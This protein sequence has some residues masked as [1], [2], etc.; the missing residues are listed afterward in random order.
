MSKNK[1]YM[2]LGILI[3]GAILLIINGFT[4]ARY[5]ANSIWN[6]YLKSKGFYFGSDDLSMNGTT[7]INNMWD[8]GNVYFNLTNSLND[9]VATDNDITY[10]VT[11]EVEGTD[12]EENECSVYGST[13]VSGVPT[14]QKIYGCK[15]YKDDGVDTSSL[16]QS[17]CESGG[18]NWKNL[19]VYKELYFNVVN[20]VGG[21]TNDVA[22]NIIATSLTP[23]RKTITGRFV[24]HRASSNMGTVSL[25]Y[26]NY[27]DNDRLVVTNSYNETRCV[28][29]TWNASQLLIDVD[30]TNLISHSTDENGYIND[31]RFNLIGKDS[32]SYI[33]YK[34][35]IQNVYDSSAF[36]IED[37]DEC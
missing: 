31:I 34:R 24:L 1:K 28:H 13:L 21:Q 11:C 2:F 6:Y 8:G 26:H 36:T 33:F 35:N 3:L 14:I 37:D 15:N 20:T 27:T 19:S 16:N 17:T 9:S 22:V 10:E 5:A 12:A 25:T 23:Y 7:N 4:Y 29:L 32:T 30:T 18:Y